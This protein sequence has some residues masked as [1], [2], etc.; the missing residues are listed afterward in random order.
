MESKDTNFKKALIVESQE[1]EPQDAR[2]RAA[3]TLQKSVSTTAIEKSQPTQ[4]AKATVTK[5]SL[6]KDIRT[7]EAAY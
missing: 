4:T 2:Q 7:A 6:L 3:Q 1:T 5:N